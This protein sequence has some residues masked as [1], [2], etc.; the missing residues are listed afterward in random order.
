MSD[1]LPRARLRALFAAV[2]L[3]FSAIAG[4]TTAGAAVP[5]ALL[6]W[7]LLYTLAGEPYGFSP[8]AI[9][10]GPGAYLF[11][12]QNPPPWA[13]FDPV[14]GRLSGTPGIA[15]VGQYPGI[16][17][18]LF[19]GLGII[20][21]P[22]FII[23]VQPPPPV[24][25]LSSVKLNWQAPDLNTDGSPLSDLAGYFIY[26]GS[27]P[28]DLV[29]YHE[30]NDPASLATTVARLARGRVAYFAIS[31]YTHDGRESELSGVVAAVVD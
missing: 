11:T 14:T 2:C 26:V 10:N 23:N 5:V 3:A 25:P 13:T 22:E 24:V 20:T 17:I 1:F 31:A 19:T 27:N 15:D 9:V 7:P 4:T 12:I 30:V 18:S 28:T 8:I 29:R 16:R 21:M 6:G